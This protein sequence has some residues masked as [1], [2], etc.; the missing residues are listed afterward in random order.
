M[1]SHS[2]HT[3]ASPFGASRAGAITSSTNIAAA[4]STVASCSS[5]FEP[6]WAK[7]PLLLIPVASA[8][9]P[10]DSGSRPSSVARDAATSR[11]A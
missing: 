3:R 7:S 9:R 2:A 4:W 10:I 11:I 8:R 5:S 6:K 1:F